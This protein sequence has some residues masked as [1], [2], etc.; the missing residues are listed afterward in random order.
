ME[1]SDFESLLHWTTINPS[2]RDLHDA[3]AITGYT[4]LR[5]GELTQLRWND[6]SF[7]HRNL[8]VRNGPFGCRRV[9]F[10][11][12][13]RAVLVARRDRHPDA[14]FVFG[15]APTRSGSRLGKQLRSLTNELDIRPST[16]SALRHR[17]AFRLFEMAEC[18]PTTCYILGH[19]TPTMYSGW[20]PNAEQMF[21]SAARLV[22]KLEGEASETP[23]HLS[24][25]IKVEDGYPNCTNGGI[26]Y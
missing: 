19:R 24:P 25:P 2:L 8:T 18:V 10:A 5:P 22:A 12:K 14:E 26:D 20:T 21:E 3:L 7:E 17:F 15:P 6:V 16:F 4:G 1:D 11:E 23:R 13:T 9:P